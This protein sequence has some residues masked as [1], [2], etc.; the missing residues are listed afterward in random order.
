MAEHRIRQVLRFCPFFV[1]LCAGGQL[2]AGYICQLGTPGPPATNVGPNPAPNAGNT[3]FSVSTTCSEQ[4]VTTNLTQRV[5]LFSTELRVRQLGGPLLLDQTFAAAFTDPVV[6]SALMNAQQLLATQGATGFF[7]PT[8]LS[9]IS[10]LSGS[11]LSSR[12]I[13]TAAP[14][15]FVTGSTTVGGGSVV[16]QNQTAIVRTGDIGQCQ[17]VNAFTGIPFGCDPTTGSPLTVVVGTVDFHAN[18]HTLYSIG[19]TNTTT[20]TFL[21]SQSYELDG[22]RG[23]A[24][25]P[26]PGTLAP[27]GL[28]IAGLWSL[29]LRIR[30]T[31]TI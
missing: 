2:T 15:N 18:S 19:V 1:L 4:V 25:I 28:A 27:M 21:T 17:G 29:R 13:Q 30:R 3:T 24:N 23:P 7:G 26:E 9:N 11:T 22:T 12:F 10:T 8:L 31:R 14:Q 16:G 5:D 6:Q 20:N